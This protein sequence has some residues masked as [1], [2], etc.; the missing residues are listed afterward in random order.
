MK[1]KRHITLVVI[2]LAG[3]AGL[4][5][6]C[7]D[8]PAPAI[9]ADREVEAKIGKILRK[10][11]L[12]EKVGQMTQLTSEYIIE[13]GTHNVSLQG[14]ALIRKYKIGSVLNTM[15]DVADSASAYR[16]F[17]GQIQD[18]SMDEMGIPCLYGLDQIH[19][20]SYTLGAVLFPHEIGLAASFNDEL[21]YEVGRISAYETRACN[22][23]WVFTP[24][25]DLSR[26]QCWPRMWES[27]GEDPLVQ[28][29]MGAALTKGLQGEDPNHIDA[30]HVAVSIKHFLAYGASVSGQDRTPSML[31]KREIKEKFFP[32]FKAAI[33]AGA[34][35]LMVSSSSNDGVP[36]HSNRELLTDWVKKG[37]NWDGMIVTD[38]ADI[39]CLY[40]RDH[41]APTYKD[42]IAQSINA[43]VDMIMEPYSTEVCD[44]L[45]EL[46]KE[47]KVPMS[48]IDDAVRR[49]LR[50]KIRLG[51]FDDPYSEGSA[52]GHFGSPEFERQA[53]RTALE[54]EVLLKNRDGLLPLP[55]N[56]RILLV[57]PNANSMRPLGGGW[58][59]SWQGDQAD[60]PE[61]TGRYNTIY[62][63]LCTKFDNVDYLPV[64]EY[65]AYGD[66][67][68]ETRGDYSAALKAAAKADVV[69][70][71]LGENSYCETKG[72]ISDLSLSANQ[73]ELVKVLSAAGKPMVLVLNEGRPRVISDI[74][75]LA[76]AVVSVLLPGNYGGD[77]LAALL[78]GEENFSARLPYTYPKYVNRLN[79]Y[80]YKLCENRA[81]MEGLYDYSAN[82]ESQWPFGYGLS[83]TTFEYSNMK[84]DRQEFRPGD[85][86]CVSVDV[87]N[88]GSVAGKE[89]VLLFSSDLCASLTPDVRRLRDYR[90]IYLEPGQ[91]TTV[92]FK[93]KAEDLAFVSEDLEW[94]LEPGEFRL[95]AGNQ[96]ATIS[97]TGK[98]VTLKK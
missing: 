62:E 66:F 5:C 42:A 33:E 52:F 73:R 17:I 93:L 37:L 79:T 65:P 40:D 63:A 45:V 39:K 82:I 24:T 43:G 76:D 95:A 11:T 72:N 22:V 20:A 83:Y 67:R 4:L 19:G 31:S 15:N 48:R 56:S 58:N 55:K 36:F 87:T 59:Y 1:H 74:E 38:W 10:M 61:F 69:V 28:S 75:P 47:K 57:G 54:T 29:R 64:L 32:P 85:I 9:T 77:A 89:A 84:T 25:L 97:Y 50:L 46:V 7:Q 92:S 30:E 14:E 3:A 88:T 41:T 96:Y 86:V 98:K 90:K 78:C 26:N 80:D 34:L 81:T 12:E 6:S 70:L 13:A 18:I 71:A 2:A 27:F 23:P 35:S 60:R 49:I 91:S 68:Q 94:V 21:S 53:Y 8:G 16:Q 44:L 51:L